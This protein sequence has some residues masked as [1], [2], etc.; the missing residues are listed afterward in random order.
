MQVERIPHV[1]AKCATSVAPKEFVVAGMCFGCL[2]QVNLS[3]IY[4]ACI[5]SLESERMD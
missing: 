3:D 2:V 5:S 4:A 1:K